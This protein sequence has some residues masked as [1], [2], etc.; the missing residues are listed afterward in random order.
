MN[1]PNTRILIHNVLML[2]KTIALVFATLIG[3]VL[4]LGEPVH[5]SMK[6]LVITKACGALTLYVCYQVFNGSLN[7]LNE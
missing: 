6:A 7:N 5:D 3:I 1:L 4:I 2:T